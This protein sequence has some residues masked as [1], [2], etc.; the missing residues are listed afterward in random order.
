MSRLARIAVAML[1]V[2]ARDAGSACATATVASM[3][4]C[5]VVPLAARA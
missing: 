1:F 4:R 3:R 2:F 5:S